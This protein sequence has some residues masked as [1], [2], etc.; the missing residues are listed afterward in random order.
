MS[1][2]FEIGSIVEGKITEIK[3]FGAFV[4]LDDQTQGLVHI[5]QISHE[6]V[7]NIHD[8]VSI[9]DAVKVKVLSIDPNSKKISL[10]MREAQPA[11]PPRQYNNTKPASKNQEQLKPQPP[12][13]LEDKLKD[14]L[15]Q[16]N[17]R[18]AALNKRS[19]K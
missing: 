11:P 12:A 7:K 18:Q 2:K 4:A 17:E 14:W 9:G 10:S 15:K 8:I 5:S 6:F 13:T 3:P 19:R 1:E 16:S